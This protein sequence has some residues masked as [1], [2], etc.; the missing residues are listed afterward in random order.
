MDN[1]ELPEGQTVSF[2]SGFVNIIGRPNAG[3]STLMNALVGERMSII[4]HKPQ[5]TRH[6]IIGI[7]TGETFQLVF[8]DTPGYVHDPSYKMHQ[9]MNRFVESTKEDAD[10]LLLVF[11]LTE[12]LEDANPI[13]S[14]LAGSD[15]PI[16]LVLNKTDLVQPQRVEDSY[17]WWRKR[18]KI[19]DYVAISALKSEHTSTLLGKILAYIPEGPAYYPT[20]QLTDRPERFFVSEIIREKIFLRYSD[21]VPYSCEVG[22]DS[23]Q[24]STTTKG[25]AIARIRAT[26]FVIRESQKGIL[27]GKNGSAIKNLGIAAR[28]AIEEFLQTKVHLELTVKVRDNW[29]D[30]DR[31]LQQFGYE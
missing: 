21:E 6:R 24:E 7:L 20:D 17:N 18:L 3:K 28:L 5:T 9:A 16:L 31:A 13:L 2:R 4:T 15:A 26:I 30:D 29:R 10:L 19:A 14:M 11:D 23:F 8:S 1:A 22:I 27:L 12:E 25:E